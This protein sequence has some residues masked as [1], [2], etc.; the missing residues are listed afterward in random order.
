[1]N[2][3]PYCNRGIFQRLAAIATLQGQFGRVLANLTSAIMVLSEQR[4]SHVRDRWPRVVIQEASFYVT[5][6]AISPRILQ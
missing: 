4:S 6:H 5:E 1:M 2:S 3:S